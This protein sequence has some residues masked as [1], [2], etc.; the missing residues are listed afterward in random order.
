[1]S[2]RVKDIH[3]DLIIAD[4]WTEMNYPWKN[5]AGLNRV[6]YSKSHAQVLL[7]GNKMVHRI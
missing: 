3:R 4:Q 2:Q 6:N 1:M 5:P 7:D